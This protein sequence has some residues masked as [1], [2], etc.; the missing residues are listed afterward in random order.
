MLMH[1]SDFVFISINAVIFGELV[2]VVEDLSFVHAVLFRLLT[3][4][5][6]QVDC[7]HD[8]LLEHQH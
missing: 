2:E 6:Y 4:G 5:L 1:V 8:N 3:F 7:V